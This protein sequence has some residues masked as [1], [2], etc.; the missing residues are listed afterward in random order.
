MNSGSTSPCCIRRRAF[1]IAGINDDDVR[2][3]V[4]RGFNDFYADVYGP[5]QDRM[6]VAA[7]IPM[8]N[9]AEALDELERCHRLGFRVVGF[10]EGVTRPIPE[11]MPDNPTPFLMPGQTHWFDTFGLDSEYDYDPVWARARELKYAA[12][13]HGGLGHMPTQ[14]FTSISNY[15]FNHI[16]AFGARMHTLVKSLFMGGVTR[17]FSDL[18]FAVL[19]CGVGWAAIL[20]N[21]I[22]EH[23]EKRNI[24]GLAALDPATIDWDQLVSLVSTH[25]GDLVERGGVAVREGVA[26]LPGVGVPPVD[27]DEWRLLD[28]ASEKDLIERF[29][30]RF[31]F[32]CE[33]DDR[34]TAFA[35]SSANHGG[36]RLNAIFSSDLGHWDAGDMSRVVPHAWGL[37]EDGVLTEDDFAD[38]VY[39][40][41]T[42]L[43]L[44]QNP[45]FFAGTPVN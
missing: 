21:D 38:F 31:Y 15:S 7:V 34:T 13:F 39:R 16:G 37:V 17:R 44:G 4:C 30:P 19:E 14:N 27:L 11:P 29:V 1:G 8:H 2:I 18:N 28:V 32:G 25:A 24:E 12:T 45:D 35:F 43:F 23:W 3:G 22:I 26:T 20:L 9:P 6:A 42:R 36:A 33:A 10:P 41:P 40:N 5:F